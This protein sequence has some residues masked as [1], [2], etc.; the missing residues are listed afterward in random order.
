VPTSP[1]LRFSCV[2]DEAYRELLTGLSS[3][4][5]WYFEPI[6]GHN[7]SSPEVFGLCKLP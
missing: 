7:A 1:L 3:T 2:S 5:T 4:V 6:D